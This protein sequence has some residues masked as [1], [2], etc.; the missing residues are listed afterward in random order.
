MSVREVV[1]EASAAVVETRDLPHEAGE[2]RPGLR[3]KVSE[4]LNPVPCPA[5]RR[6][7]VVQKRE[8]A[9]EHAIASRALLHEV[10]LLGV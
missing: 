4:I 7:E 6:G 9:G 8:G 10:G 5:Q 3:V 2:Q 1:P